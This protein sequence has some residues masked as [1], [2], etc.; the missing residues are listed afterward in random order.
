MV[1]AAEQPADTKISRPDQHR[2]SNGYTSTHVSVGERLSHFT[3]SRFECTML[4][5]TIVALL[6]QQPSIFNALESFF[7]GAFWVSIALLLYNVRQYGV[8][9]KGPWLVSALEVLFWIYL[10]C[11]LLVV[12]FQYHNIFEKQEPSASGAMPAWILPAYP[13]LMLGPLASVLDYT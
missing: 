2:H 11:A 9:S 4:T 7:F 5:G 12:I 13:F 6:G 3:W 8:P 1:A 10:A